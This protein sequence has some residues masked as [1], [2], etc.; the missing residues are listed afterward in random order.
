MISQ[1]VA[2]CMEKDTLTKK[3]ASDNIYSVNTL[4]SVC[5]LKVIQNVVYRVHLK[6]NRNR[7]IRDG[8]C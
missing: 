5:E 1:S 4:Y 3:V 8:R 2:D 7:G 6:N